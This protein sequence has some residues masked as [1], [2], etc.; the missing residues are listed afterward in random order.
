MPGADALRDQVAI[1]TGAS[2]G[3]GRA[4][5]FRLAEDGASVALIA[6]SLDGAEKVASELRDRFS[7]GPEAGSAPSRR[8][9]AYACDV[10]KTKDACAAVE[11]VLKDMGRIDIL[12]NNAGII[13]DALLIWMKEEEWD[14]V[15]ATN[16]KGTFNLSRAV[17]RQMLRDRRGRIINI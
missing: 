12:V 6:R 14:D 15:I 5:A 17:A 11:A 16:L 10:S 9:L 1:V 2:R 7:R 4:V 13:R 8:F 3:I